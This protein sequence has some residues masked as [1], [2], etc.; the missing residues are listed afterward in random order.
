MNKT[1]WIQEE[2]YNHLVNKIMQQLR[3]KIIK[4]IKKIKKQI[5]QRNIET[6]GSTMQVGRCTL[7]VQIA[8]VLWHGSTKH[9]SYSYYSQ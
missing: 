8:M 9:P 7:D 6:K 4:N 2:T 1:I 3:S 5:K